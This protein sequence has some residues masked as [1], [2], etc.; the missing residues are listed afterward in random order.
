MDPET[1]QNLVGGIAALGNEEL[2]ITIV[3]K[4][5]HKYSGCDVRITTEVGVPFISHQV[6]EEALKQKMED[7]HNRIPELI[8]GKVCL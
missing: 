2:G 1:Y 7:F 5:G 4:K 8:D 6:D 3:D